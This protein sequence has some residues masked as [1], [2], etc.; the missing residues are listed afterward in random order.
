MFFNGVGC[1]KKVTELAVRKSKTK[2]PFD[3]K[4]TCVS[5]EEITE[6]EGATVVP[7][8]VDHMICAASPLL[9]WIFDCSLFLI[10]EFGI[11]YAD[12]KIRLPY[13]HLMTLKTLACTFIGRYPAAFLTFGFFEG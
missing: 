9:W 12:N 5:V 10:L 2:I 6:T 4:S 7:L 11:A 3:R 8:P 13:S 1:V